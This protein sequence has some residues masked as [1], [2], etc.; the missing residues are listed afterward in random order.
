MDYIGT[1]RESTEKRHI[2]LTLTE[3]ELLQ[4]YKKILMRLGLAEFLTCHTCFEA[5]RDES[6]HAAV[7]DPPKPIFINCECCNRTYQPTK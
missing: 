5:G 1:E 2:E 3:V 6:V 4:S 7:Q